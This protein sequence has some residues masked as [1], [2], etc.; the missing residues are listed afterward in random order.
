MIFFIALVGCQAN[1]TTYEDNITNKQNRIDIKHEQNIEVKADVTMDNHTM[2]ILV[3][4]VSQDSHATLR[5]T[6]STNG[7]KGVTLGYYFEKGRKTTTELKSKTDKS[8]KKEW[9]NQR[10][11]LEKGVNAIYL[12]GE[13]NQNVKFDFILE[14]VDSANV[15]YTGLHLHV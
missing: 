15:R 9:K 7:E 12:Y 10:I 13:K 6:Y 1:S 4:E 2:N 11:L 8:Y 14:G 3:I 5:Y